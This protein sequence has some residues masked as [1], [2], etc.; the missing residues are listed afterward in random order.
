MLGMEPLFSTQ[1][2]KMMNYQIQTLLVGRKL[3]LV[4]VT[5]HA[6]YIDFKNV[7]FFIY[8]LS[9]LQSLESGEMVNREILR[10][11]NSI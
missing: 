1:T 8:S 11:E 3:L 5:S 6:F 4:L 7:L 2:A 9:A 10:D